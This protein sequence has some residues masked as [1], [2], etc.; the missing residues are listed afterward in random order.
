MFRFT[1]R[2][3]VLLTVIVAM[4]VSWWL[5]HRHQLS[6][7]GI[8]RYRAMALAHHLFYDGQTA[9]WDAQGVA[10]KNKAGETFAYPWGS[11]EPLVVH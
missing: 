1:I 2:E 6:G 11:Q 8:W 9:T 4:G 10:V 7:A 5:D 3:V